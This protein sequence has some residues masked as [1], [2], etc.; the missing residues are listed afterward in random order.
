MTTDMTFLLLVGRLGSKV[1]AAELQA[2]GLLRRIRRW[3]LPICARA[4]CP[5][6]RHPPNPHRRRADAAARALRKVS[7]AQH[8][9]CLPLLTL[10]FTASKPITR[11]P[12]LRQ[13]ESANRYYPACVSLLRLGSRS[14][15][16]WRRK[17]LPG[18]FTPARGRCARLC[19][20]W[21]DMPRWGT[22]MRR[23]RAFCP[24]GPAKPCRPRTHHAHQFLFGLLLAAAIAA[25]KGHL[26]GVTCLLFCPARPLF[27]GGG[28]GV[29]FMGRLLSLSTT[30]RGGC[31]CYSRQARTGARSGPC[32]HGESW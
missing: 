10:S 2:R 29:F 5:A 19:A 28:S 31:R 25:A 30:A 3:V 26:F 1:F 12:A 8:Q 22:R 23:A 13:R 7:S 15:R 27:L 18:C 14:R 20:L 17:F 4:N 24:S 9:L 21:Q 6:V 11:G 16:P 32:C